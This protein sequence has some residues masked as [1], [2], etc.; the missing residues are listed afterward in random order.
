M[1]RD[2]HRSRGCFALAVL[3][4]VMSYQARLFVHGSFASRSVET[5]ERVETLRALS[6]SY[7]EAPFRGDAHLRGDAHGDTARAEGR[8]A[9]RRGCDLPGDA[10]ARPGSAPARVK[11]RGRGRGAPRGSRRGDGRGPQGRGR[12]DARRGASAPGVLPRGER[13]T[14][15]RLDATERGIVPVRA[16]RRRRAGHV[17][18]RAVRHGGR[19][20]RSREPANT[21]PRVFPPAGPGE[22]RGA[23][24]PPPQRARRAPSGVRGR[25]L[26]LLTRERRRAMRG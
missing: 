9:R 15:H 21:P 16:R 10:A 18:G 13:P 12:R 14:R 25:E 4:S 17:G 23:R 5:R 22:R 7:I 26:R 1:R 3:D 2:A 19:A 8:Y 11:P 24:R 20:S 6:P